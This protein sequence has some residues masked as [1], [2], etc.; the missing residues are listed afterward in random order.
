[1]L[2]GIG[3]LFARTIKKKGSVTDPSADPLAIATLVA[4]STFAYQDR[5]PVI[6]PHDAR[7]WERRSTPHDRRSRMLTPQ[8]KKD[9]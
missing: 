6:A 5:L 1:V 3:C 9:A 2:V 7:T 4:T 8:I